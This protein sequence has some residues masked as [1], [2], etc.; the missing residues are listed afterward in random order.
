[1]ADTSA[2]VKDA[3]IGQEARCDIALFMAQS[4]L[5]WSQARV[6]LPT[7]TQL[8]AREIL[9]PYACR[10]ELPSPVSQ[11][12]AL[13]RCEQSWQQKFTVPKLW[14]KIYPAAWTPVQL[15]SLDAEDALSINVV[16]PW[17]NK[18]RLTGGLVAQ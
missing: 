1:M 8:N 3:T 18:H 16:A 17:H 15:L 10:Q 5:R 6:L 14:M 12:E 4:L 7:G 11:P 9:Y 2:A 13:V